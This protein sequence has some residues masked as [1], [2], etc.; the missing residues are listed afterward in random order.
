MSPQAFIERLMGIADPAERQGFL[1]DH[2]HTIEG[3]EQDEFINGLL[4][5]MISLMRGN[6]QQAIEVADLML[7]FATHTRK[8]LHR[9]VGLRAKAQTI[10]NG[11]GRYQESIPLFEEAIEIHQRHKDTYGEALVC[12][13]YIWA[14]AHVGRMP[15]AIAKGEWALKIFRELEDV[16]KMVILL[17]NLGL[18]QNRAGQYA[19][20]HEA[21]TQVLLLC[22]KLGGD[23]LKSVAVIENNRALAL[24]NLG[25]FSQAA[26]LSRQ[27]ARL[28][29]TYGLTAAN[30]RN[31]HTLG[32]ILF[33]QG[34]YNEAL[35]LF[36]LAIKEHENLG[37]VHEVALC[38]LSK[39]DCLL[40][41]RQF[42]EVI[43]LCN[44]LK[45]IFKGLNFTIEQAEAIRNRAS[46][47]VGLKRYSSAVEA[48]EEAQQLFLREKHILR[49]TYSDL[50]KAIC[51]RQQKRYTDSIQIALL[52]AKVFDQHNL[53]L[54]A[55]LSRLLAGWGC[56]AVDDLEQ[57]RTLVEHV[58][59]TKEASWFVRVS[60]QIL[61]LKGILAQRCG[62][63]EVALK[64]L[65]NAAQEL[66]NLR[67][68]AM[69]EH[70]VNFVEDKQAVYESLVQLWLEQGEVDK[71]LEYV[72][73]AKSR[74][75]IELVKARAETKL[76]L[77]RSADDPLM[78]QL[79]ALRTAREEKLRFAFKQIE[80]ISAENPM[81]METLQ[82]EV[83]DL[84]EQI[85]Q[86]WHQL[87]IRNQMGE[88]L[89]ASEDFQLEILQSYLD[90]ET[91]LVEYFVVE[92]QFLVFTLAHSPVKTSPQVFSLPVKPGQV[93][94]LMQQLTLNF[95]LVAKGRVADDGLLHHAQGYLHRLYQMLLQPIE[96][97]LK[98]YKKLIII[99]YAALHSV[100]FHALYD[101]EQ[102]LIENHVVSY[103]PAAT[104]L[105]FCKRTRP[106]S[107]GS[108]IIG[109]SAG[110]KLPYAIKEAQRL[111]TLMETSA[112]CEEE[113]RISSLRAHMAETRLL[114][115]ACHGDYHNDN[116]LFSGLLLEEGFLTT[117]DVFGL[118]LQ[119]SLVTLSACQTGRS[120]SGGGDELL[121][122]MR[123]FFS[124]GTVS[125]LMTLWPV[126][127][128]S[129]IL[130]MERFYR[131]I[132]MGKTKGE[133]L[134]MAQIEFLS[135]GGNTYQYRHPF[136]WAPF[137]L[138]G[139]QE[140]L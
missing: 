69:L 28:A 68:N 139:D 43:K 32:M 128:E 53:G 23:W 55:S 84:E 36:N 137:F 26:E 51:Y 48:L 73:R 89:V 130:W 133:A 127:D 50:Q 115:I 83:E 106:A 17:N 123:A 74:T 118:R 38:K 101:S 104:L 124:A 63:Q 98:K 66:E 30:A 40:E 131:L 22:Q 13:T 41:L 103:L 129:T 34:K 76:E 3:K 25:E 45:E 47:L 88:G 12:L 99:P 46:A 70:R 135:G 6:V 21:F 78:G 37:Q 56:L 54:D 126:S 52:C 5:E 18:V 58:E 44:E 19:K 102:Y 71:G 121:G 91:L 60:Y 96:Q 77:F 117:L 39:T 20:A 31:H 42:K 114:H 97:E 33:F 61:H 140:K 35:Q 86:T 24:F 49:A 1:Q 8:E 11:N 72:E 14:L 4:N 75:L 119:T 85:T 92:N 110:G 10:G 100:P 81:N 105:Q 2:W 109:H 15:E 113:A 107:Q 29:D 7:D 82:N 64:Q 16:P 79:Q 9:A 93:A 95:N 67:G 65:I 87:L 27:A 111:A 90:A 125:L 138:I 122:L 116:S 132:K 94:Q 59:L 112:F 80:S 57:A 108:L 62:E 136:F 120:K 134:Q